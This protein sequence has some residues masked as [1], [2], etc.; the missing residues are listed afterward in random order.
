MHLQKLISLNDKI[1][2][3]FPFIFNSSHLKSFFLHIRL[4]ILLIDFSYPSFS[5]IKVNNNQNLNQVLF[6]FPKTFNFFFGNPVFPIF[7]DSSILVEFKIK[8]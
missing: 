6:I 3:S 8:S 5:M 4:N 2:S 7:L 1:L